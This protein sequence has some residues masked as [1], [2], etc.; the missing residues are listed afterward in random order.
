MRGGRFLAAAAACTA[1]AGGCWF[2]TNPPEVAPPVE[3]PPDPNE[4]VLT[5]RVQFFDRVDHMTRPAPG[6]MVTVAW[7]GADGDRDGQPD[8]VDT[9]ITRAGMS[10]VYD[11]RFR[12][13]TVVAAEMRAA[14]CDYDPVLADCC[15]DIPPCPPSNCQIWGAIRRISVA[16][17]QRFQQDLV[18]PCS[19]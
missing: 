12:S 3:V 11:V 14:L 4:V 19:H 13:N 10:G 8:L 2:G 16:P 7:F 5:G 17:G 9:W 18:V 6:W 15:L 1:L